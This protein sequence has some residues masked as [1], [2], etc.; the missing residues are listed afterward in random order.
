M[1][2][3]FRQAGDVEQTVEQA[4]QDVTI[5]T[6]ATPRFPLADPGAMIEELAALHGLTA[7]LQV[8]PTGRQ[9]GAVSQ[10]FTQAGGVTTITRQ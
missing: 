10:V 7:P 9:A 3:N 1:G 8:S 2:P 6:T 5:T 4:G